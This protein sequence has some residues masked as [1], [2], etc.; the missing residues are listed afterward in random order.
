MWSPWSWRGREGEVK[1]EQVR[2][3]ESKEGLGMGVGEEGGD[4]GGGGQSL[5]VR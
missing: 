4:G 1:G 5:F 3:A 2:K